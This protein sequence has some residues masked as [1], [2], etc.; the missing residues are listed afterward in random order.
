MPA[1]DLDPFLRISRRF[2]DRLRLICGA[3]GAGG[4][5]AGLLRSARDETGRDLASLRALR[6]RGEAP[7]ADLVKVA[8]HMDLFLA[9]AE[10]PGA[11]PALARKLLE[12]LLEEQVEI[13][14]GAGGSV[15]AAP[16]GPPAAE[17]PGGDSSG[18]RGA[19]PGGR[20]ALTVGSLIG[21]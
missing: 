21:R 13:T 9:V 4:A 15:P 12:H 19:P 6:G 2:N 3:Y 8:N 17:G 7:D 16:A 10:P 5:P 11:P 20:P 14:E 1:P 18:P